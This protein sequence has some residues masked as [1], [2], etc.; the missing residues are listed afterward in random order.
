M[1]LESTNNNPKKI[2]K[3]L[4]EEIYRA[5]LTRTPKRAVRH[6]SR[7]ESHPSKAYQKKSSLQLCSMTQGQGCARPL[8]VS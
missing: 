7:R 2:P 6:E 3:K 4:L 8:F 1:Q 5:N